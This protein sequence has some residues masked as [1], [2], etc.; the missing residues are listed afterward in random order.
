MVQV[1]QL[2]CTIIL[3]EIDFMSLKLLYCKSKYKYVFLMSLILFIL[4]ILFTFL[5]S[6]LPISVL[7]GF[8]PIEFESASSYVEHLLRYESYLYGVGYLQ[9]ILPV[10]ATCAV[11]GFKE[12]VYHYFFHLFTRKGRYNQMIIKEL[13]KNA[14]IT[15]GAFYI[16]YCLTACIAYLLLPCAGIDYYAIDMLLADIFGTSLYTDYLFLFT[17]LSGIIKVFIP[18]FVYSLFALILTLMT[19]KTWLVLV[20]PVLYHYAMMVIVPLISY[21]FDYNFYIL[22]FSPSFLIQPSGFSEPS[23]L[24]IMIGYIPYFIIF[25]VLLH[26]VL[27]SKERVI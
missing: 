26:K 24:M 22:Y 6:G 5:N 21:V 2:T 14:F 19:K 4:I 23:T 10:L 20:T 27:R 25:F 8:H 11:Y 7:F 12:Q 13:L 9:Y 1:T 17:L 16:A 3:K 18:T 15:A